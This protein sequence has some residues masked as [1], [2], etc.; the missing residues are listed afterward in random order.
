LLFCVIGHLHPPD[1]YAAYLKYSPAQEGRWQRGGQ[2]Y[3]RELAYY[4]AHQVGQTLDLLRARYPHYVHYAPVWGM[5][6]SM[7]P[8]EWVEVYYCP[9]ARLAQITATPADPLEEEVA[10]LAEAIFAATG[11]SRGSLGVT[12]SILLGIHAPDFSDIDL[13]V[14]GRE[15][16]AR[17]RVALS[18]HSIPS[19]APLDEAF[20]DSWRREVVAHHALTDQQVRW[21][22]AR[23]W[24]FARSGQGRY[25]SLLPVR[26]DAA[27]G[28]AYGEHTYRDAGDAW[29]RAVV[30][31]ATDAI[32]LPAIYTVGKVEI[33]EGPAVEVVE[34][35]AYETLFCQAADVGQQVEARGKLEQVDGGPR[36]R[37]VIG[38]GR[39][40]GTEYLV[41]VS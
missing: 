6:F 11:I 18:G 35:C 9:E 5:E 22:E 14:Y 28:E 20:L 39:R 36:H 29:L 32:F 37:L 10:R 2:A 34:I 41:P 27:I 24:N 38:S 15:N 30:A 12:G 26:D 23:R 40:S 16:V 4:H 3:H 31:N 8:R 25:L 21:L 7:V 33:L 19:I 13:T 17:L 1:R